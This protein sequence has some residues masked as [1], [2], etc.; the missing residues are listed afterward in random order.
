MLIL[1]NPH[2]P[3]GRAWTAA[4]LEQLAD[5]CLRHD[6]LI[7]SDEIHS[8][9]VLPAY[10]HI[11]L[12]DL[13]ERAAASTITCMAP[14]KTFNIAGL[15]TSSVIISNPDLKKKFDTCMQSLRITGGNIFGNE[16]SIAAYSHGD[17]W[18]DEMLSYVNRNIEYVLE[19][20]RNN[21]LIRPVPPEATYMIWLD[22]RAMG[23]KPDELNKFFV[24]EAAVGMSEGS[25][26]GPGGEGFMR[27]NV[28]CRLDTVKEAVENMETALLK[29]E[30]K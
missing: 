23:M 2:N 21:K 4:E 7:L 24:D 26:F 18:L 27:M 17:E 12:A 8:D 30:N 28:A 15:S 20:F 1:C 29:L 5:I 22:C 3:V 10:R 11:P 14:S 25:V 16:A 19:K 9:L 6:I 13:S